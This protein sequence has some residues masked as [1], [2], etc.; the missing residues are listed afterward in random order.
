MDGDNNIYGPSGGNLNA[1]NT[2]YQNLMGQQTGAAQSVANVPGQVQSITSGV[3]SNPYAAGAQTGANTAGA[4]GTGSV[5]PAAQQG[6]GALQGLGNQNSGY[7]GQALAQGFDPQNALYNRGYQQT[8][9]QSNAINAMSGVS[10]SPYGAGVTQQA[11]TNFNLGWDQNQLANQAT[12]AG[13]ANTLSGAAGNAYSGA[14]TLGQAAVTGQATDSALPSQQYEQNILSQLQ[15]LSAGNQTTAGASN[16]TDQ[17]LSQLLSYLGYGT[18]ATTAQQ[19][20]SNQTFAGIGNLLGSLGG[21][22][23]GN[24]NIFSAS[25]G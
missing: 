7:V 23:L 6:A 12:A 25:G 9:D 11:G 8:I 5:V 13:T 19:N 21:A 4:Y 24:P 15:G 3:T 2:S 14:N 17:S 16:I 22:A 1:A 20:Q 10:N 18:S